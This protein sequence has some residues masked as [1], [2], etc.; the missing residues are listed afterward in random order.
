VLNCRC[1]RG[2]KRNSDTQMRVLS[3]LR[4]LDPEWGGPVEGVR[5]MSQAL[6]ALTNGATSI[7]S[8]YS[9]SPNT[10]WHSD[11]NSPVHA[12]GAGKFG[13]YGY[14]AALARWLRSEVKRLEC[15][16]IRERRISWHAKCRRDNLRV[17]THAVF[18]AQNALSKGCEGCASGGPSSTSKHPFPEDADWCVKGL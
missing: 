2:V 17:S 3:V 8:A 6:I 4:T 15:M 1:Q 14:N 13:M 16:S 5:R 9:D 10:T 18:C 12:L 7:E 11:W